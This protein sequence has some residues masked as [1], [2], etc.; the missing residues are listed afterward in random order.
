MASSVESRVS[1][2]DHHLVE[3]VNSLPPS[4]KIM[5]I[6]GDKLGKWTL[7]EKWILREAVKPF[8]T[9]EI[10]LRKKVAFNPLPMPAAAVPSALNP[11]QKH[12]KARITQASVEKL[13]FV[14]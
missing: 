11:L 5:P 7:V 2:L 6:A 1:F 9:E 10:Y 14:D 13:G 12:L 3:Y 4:L 8:V